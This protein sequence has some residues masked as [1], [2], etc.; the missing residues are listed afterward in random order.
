MLKRT[1]LFLLAALALTGLM[2]A[3]DNASRPE[4]VMS[5]LTQAVN[6]YRQLNAQQELV[7]EPNDEVFLHDNR[8]LAEQ[9]VRFSFDYGRAQA[10]ALSN[11]STPPGQPVNQQYQNLA[12]LLAKANQRVLDL[13]HELDGS[14]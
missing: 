14:K 9:V 2:A 13:Q 12:D 10:Q 5:F 7:N 6:W 8:Q 11:A 1:I 4:D 3:G